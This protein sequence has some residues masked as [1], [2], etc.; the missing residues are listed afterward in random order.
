MKTKFEDTK[1]FYADVASLNLSELKALAAGSLKELKKRSKSLET[2]SRN[3]E[4]FMQEVDRLDLDIEGILNSVQVIEMLHPL[5]T[6]RDFA[7]KFQLK[8][9][10][11]ASDFS[12]NQKIY[13]KYAQIDAASLS[14]DASYLHQKVM[15]GYKS[16]GVDQSKEVR[17]QVKKM[18]KVQAELA[19][20]FGRNIT[21]SVPTLKFKTSELEGCHQDFI[22]RSTKKGGEVAEIRLTTTAILQILQNCQIRE[23]RERVRE[24]SLNCAKESNFEVLPAYL[25]SKEELACLLGYKNYAQISTADK[26]I[27]NPENA[28]QFIEDLL[29]LTKSRVQKELNLIKKYKKE[30]GDENPL[31]Y[32]D[33]DFYAAQIVNARTSLDPE[34]LQQ[35][36]PYEH[37]KTGI[38]ATFEEMF[39]LKFK[40]DPDLKLWH[41]DA[42]GYQVLDADSNDLIGLVYLDMHPRKGKFSGACQIDVKTGLEKISAPQGLLVCNF[43]KPEGNNSGLQSLDDVSTFFHEFGHLMHTILGGQKVRWAAFSGARVQW[44]FVEAPSQLME[45]ILLSPEVLKRLSRHIKTGQSLPNDL[46][47]KVVE[48]DSISFGAKLKGIG[49]ARQAALSKMSLLSYTTRQIDNAKLK[50]IEQGSTKDALSVYGD[51]YQIYDFGHLIGYNSNYYTYMWSLAIS[52]DLFSAFNP[53]YL[54]DK[55]IS[56]KYRREILEPGGSRPAAELVKQFLGR[57]WG[58]DA[59]KKYL[60]DGEELLEA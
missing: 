12:L 8:L 19:T 2:S 10:Q 22:V 24:V 7:S 52:K 53:K 59:F 55:S 45:E 27:Q 31:S 42:E 29:S 9:S 43:N 34:E 5:K 40:R 50:Q 23:T 18:A 44:D 11:F 30:A 57:E 56:M 36:F 1:P 6:F 17:D 33:L 48:S 21:D 41:Q 3:G 49:I 28:A 15:L 60:Q 37:V 51:Y 58:L 26:M 32:A 54:T 16:S 38:L 13:K 47:A 39:S 4:D 14:E 35:Y 20:N 25:K 46:I